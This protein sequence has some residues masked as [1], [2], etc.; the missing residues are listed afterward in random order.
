MNAK[1][2]TMFAVVLSIASVSGLASANG[3]GSKPQPRS[4]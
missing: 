4:G 1:A 2:F 3:Y